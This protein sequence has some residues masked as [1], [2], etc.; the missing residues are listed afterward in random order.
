MAMDVFA[1]IAQRRIDEAMENGEFVNLK[2]SGRP[3]VLEDDTMIPEDLRMAYKVLKNAGCVPPEIELRKEIAC[4]KDLINT[5]DDDKERLRKI[6]E[7][8]F[9]LMKL[10]MMRGRPLLYTVSPEYESRVVEKIVG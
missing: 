5:L 2:G 8:N 7:F 6:S 1:R 4:L 3:L 10:E 9:K